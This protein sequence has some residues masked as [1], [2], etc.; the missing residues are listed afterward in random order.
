MD[1]LRPDLSTQ[2]NSSTAGLEC[3]IQD[4]WHWRPN[5]AP[6]FLIARRRHFGLSAV[7]H[8]CNKHVYFSQTLSDVFR[9]N[10]SSSATDYA[11]SYTFLHSV[12]CLPVVCLPH[13]CPLLKP[14]DR[15]WCLLTSTHGGLGV[16][17]KTMLD[18]VPDPREGRFGGLNP[19]PKNAIA[20]YSQTVNPM[21]PSGEY[22]REL[23]WTWL[24][25]VIPSFPTLLWS[26]F[27]F[28]LLV[29]LQW[30]M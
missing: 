16:L 7:H 18:G 27:T 25:R 29:N 1:R 19:Q 10:R 5:A 14:L 28:R 8:R 15:F 9:R 17:W 3:T 22:K 20:N 26:L 6:N 11:Y 24:D 21:L 2:W 12:V 30:L 13:S 23:G 4:I